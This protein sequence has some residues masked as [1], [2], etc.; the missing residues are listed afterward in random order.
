VVGVPQCVPRQ[1]CKTGH[2][3]NNPGSKQAI[4]LDRAA[5]N[6]NR[7]TW[8]LR[9]GGGP[10]SARA[11]SQPVASGQPPLQGQSPLMPHREL[12]QSKAVPPGPRSA[13]QRQA[14]QPASS[15]HR[16][17]R[18][19]NPTSRSGSRAPEFGAA[20]RV[21][22]PQ[23]RSLPGSGRNFTCRNSPGAER[24]PLRAGDALQALAGGACRRWK[25][26]EMY[27]A[28]PAPEGDR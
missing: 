26:C 15:P 12:R 3:S 20:A 6:Q 1:R 27:A 28:T 18:P 2:T 16:R 24:P 25:S 9:S 19:Q 13:K 17:N 5:R 10:N 14:P 11:N 22:P 21:R 7:Q 23:S 8:P 4:G